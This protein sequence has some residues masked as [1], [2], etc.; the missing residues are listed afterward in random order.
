MKSSAKKIEKLLAKHVDFEAYDYSE[1]RTSEYWD[2]KL[3]NPVYLRHDISEAEKDWAGHSMEFDYFFNE[4]KNITADYPDFESE[5]K[6]WS[7]TETINKIVKRV[8]GALGWENR[9]EGGLDPYLEQTSFN[10]NARTYRTDI[11]IVDYPNEAKYIAEK[12]GDEKLREARETVIMPVEVKYW[13]RL[14]EYRQGKSEEKKKID[15]KIDESSKTM[16]PNEQTVNYMSMLKKKWGILTDGATWRLFNL[17]LSSEDPERFYEFNFYAFLHN[18]VTNEKPESSDELLAASKYFFYFFSKYAFFPQDGSEPIVDEILR[19]SK[20]YVLKVEQDLKERFILA[21]NQACNS[22]ALHNKNESDLS[23]IRNVAESALFNLLFI[24]S[25]ETRGVLP[26]SS[27]DYKKIS[28]TSIVDK[29]EKFDPEKDSETNTRNLVRAFQQGNGNSFTFLAE[30]TELHERIVRLTGVIHKGASKSD[31]FGF[32]IEGFRE[33]VFS[34]DEWDLFKRSKISNLDWVKILFKLNYADSE[35]KNRK[36]QQ[37]PYAFFTPR[38]LGSIYESFLE[39]K[40]SKSDIDRQF[41]GGTWKPLPSSKANKSGERI[42]KG[43]LFFEKDTARSATGSYYTPH[44]VVEFMLEKSI[45]N[46]LNTTSLAAFLDYKICDPAMGSGHFLCGAMNSLATRLME[47]LKENPHS[48]INT[49]NDAKR[50]VLENCIFGVDI[51]KRAVKLAK[52]SLWL[53]TATIGKPIQNLD[54]HLKSG[55]SLVPPN[56][57]YKSGFNWQIEFKSIFQKGGFDLVLGNPPW[58]ALLDDIKDL[59]KVQFNL[60]DIKNINSFDLFLRRGIDLIKFQGELVFVL[61]RNILRSEDYN[62]LRREFVNNHLNYFADIGQAFEGVT[63]EAVVLSLDRQ[64]RTEFT[65]Y[66]FWKLALNKDREYEQQTILTKTV[67]SK[68]LIDQDTAALSIYSSAELEG[69]FKKI[70][71]KGKSLGNDYLRSDSRGLE[72]GG[73]G[74]LGVCPYCK[75]TMTKPKK[76]KKSSKECHGCGKIIS[77]EKMGTTYVINEK[78]TSAS[79]PEITAGR[80]IGA[81]SFEKTGYLQLGVDEIN[82]K[83]NVFNGK[84]SIFMSKTSGDL[85]AYFD[86]DGKRFTTQSAL[87]L[88]PMNRKIGFWLTALLNSDVLNFFYEYSYVGGA[89]LT[90]ALTKDILNSLPVP[91]VDSVELEEIEKIVNAIQMGTIDEVKMRKLN[92]IVFGAFGLTKKEICKIKSFMDFCNQLKKL[93]VT[94]KGVEEFTSLLQTA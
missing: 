33:S 73:N 22:I 4:I 7:E 27:T 91:L 34:K 17:E 23:P 21:I 60:D 11:L 68:G 26:M 65:I 72:I 71:A 93:E 69:L 54:N 75:A 18:L 25:L 58:G 15:S 35:S 92:D 46:T 88:K 57:D 76:K 63:Q 37:I 3:F 50:M 62:N 30:G 81:F 40:M 6:N 86:A 56:K 48:K 70:K 53:E 31:K 52:L 77:L 13:R 82:Y 47:L 28:L 29:I 44:R 64:P 89:V 14:E 49:K 83:P 10:F 61:P 9:C 39:Y 45:Q 5:F 36:Y 19:D 84:P 78:K 90:T 94:K 16:T 59:I 24:R 85:R 51:N 32:E 1:D 12:D 80:G 8:L 38:Q 43:E 74:E 42:K 79:S 55:D 67:V 2:S 66:P 20:K 41:E 87:V